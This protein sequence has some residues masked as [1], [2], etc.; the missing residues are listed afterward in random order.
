MTSF[1]IAFL[2]TYD[3]LTYYTNA[4]LVIIAL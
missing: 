4:D 1:I 2:I 3:L